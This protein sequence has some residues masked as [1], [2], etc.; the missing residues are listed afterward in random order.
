MKLSKHQTEHHIHLKTD[1]NLLPVRPRFER[2]FVLYL[3]I[4]S[5]VPV[6]ISI[7]LIVLSIVVSNRTTFIAAQMDELR[8][9]ISQV[10]SVKKTSPAVNLYNQLDK[11]IK[12]IQIT[13]IDWATLWNTM[14]TAMPSTMRWKSATSEVSS[15]ENKKIVQIKLTCETTNASD[16][17]DYY[18]ALLESMGAVIIQFNTWEGNTERG[19]GLGTYFVVEYTLDIPTKEGG[20]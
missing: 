17:P 2:R 15:D 7:V 11:Q 16:I 9:R 14:T 18:D 19:E 20:Q 12:E 6:F 8:T 1:I 13:N 5:L 3:L 4:G 10:S